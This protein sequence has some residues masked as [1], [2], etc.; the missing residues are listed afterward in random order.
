ME[1]GL[2]I[3]DIDHFIT[4]NV[5]GEKQN[6]HPYKRQ[7]G[8]RK[9]ISHIMT[10]TID[11]N[12]SKDLDDALSVENLS[13]GRQQIGV[14]ITD[15][16]DSVEKDGTTDKGAKS[17]GMSIPMSMYPVCSAAIPMLPEAIAYN[18]CSL[19]KH[20]DRN[21]ISVFFTV[22]EAQSQYIVEAPSMNLT[23]IN[24]NHQLH[25]EEAERILGSP[26]P[27]KI[28]VSP[29]PRRRCSTFFN[30]NGWTAFCIP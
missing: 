16:S 8:N 6:R 11:P 26:K 18:H 14:H 9:D 28:V 13:G 30:L 24:S 17:Q 3:L 27:P 1:S 2:K 20:N 29:D 25:Y 7:Y 21:T 5:E 10:F 23:V 12:G 15:V 19:K 22:T 4:R